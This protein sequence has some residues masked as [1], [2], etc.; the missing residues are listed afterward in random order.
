VIIRLLEGDAA[1]RAPIEA[2]LLPLKGA[3]KFL[4]VSLL[5]RLE[6]RVK[7]LR[8]GDAVLLALYDKFFASPE[9]GLL[10]VSAAVIE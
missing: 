7:P 9:V 8:A 2:R 5:A 4:L 10:D 1:T 3:G 6:C